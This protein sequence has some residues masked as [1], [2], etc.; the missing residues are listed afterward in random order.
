VIAEKRVLETFIEQS[1]DRRGIAP[2]D[3]LEQPRHLR[4]NVGVIHGVPLF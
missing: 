2:V 4:S 1:Q 3:S